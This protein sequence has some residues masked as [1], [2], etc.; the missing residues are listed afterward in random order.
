M[1]PK[2][3]E[4]AELHGPPP[5]SAAL[6][7]TRLKGHLGHLTTAEEDALD[8]FKVVCAKEGFYKPAGSNS[9][10][11]HD[12]GTLVY[13]TLEPSSCFVCCSFQSKSSVDDSYE[14]G[15]STLRM[16][17]YSSKIQRYGGEI[18]S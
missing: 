13:A 11:S 3:R 18:T 2:Q 15:S 6:E 17:L 10:A 12:D 4:E 8:E 7:Q 5:P 9:P 1:A 16:L 14:L